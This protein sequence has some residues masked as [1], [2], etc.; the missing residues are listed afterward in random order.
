MEIAEYVAPVVQ[1][2]LPEWA[3]VQ[4]ILCSFPHGLSLGDIVRYRICVIDLIVALCSCHEE[5]P[6]KPLAAVSWESF[7][8]GNAKESKEAVL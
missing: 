2:Q 1:Y 8:V 3:R 6:P 4:E 5:P 7:G